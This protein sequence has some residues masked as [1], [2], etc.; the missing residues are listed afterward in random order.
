LWPAPFFFEGIAMGAEKDKEMTRQDKVRT[1]RQKAKESFERAALVTDEQLG[2]ALGLVVDYVVSRHME[3]GMASPA[4][5]ISLALMKGGD[6]CC[7]VNDWVDRL[8][9]S[10]FAGTPGR[11][12]VGLAEKLVNGEPWKTLPGAAK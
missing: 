9:L 3:T 11:A 10:C 4:A 1:D 2:V 6:W 12:V 7:S 8:G 5:K